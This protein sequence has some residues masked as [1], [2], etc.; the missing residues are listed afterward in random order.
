VDE[1]YRDVGDPLF[2]E[3]K[4]LDF[5]LER[6]KFYTEASWAALYQQSPF[7]VRGGIFRG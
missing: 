5:L 4:S 7:I 1:E 3:L 2:P 6:R